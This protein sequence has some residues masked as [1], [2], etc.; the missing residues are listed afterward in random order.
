MA[1][2]T[3]SKENIHAIVVNRI[4]SDTQLNMAQME[5]MLGETPLVAITPMPELVFTATRMKTTAIATRPDSLT[6]QQFTKLATTLLDF[7]KQKK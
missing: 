5:E 1:E 6:A 3:G 7:E 2:L 4:R